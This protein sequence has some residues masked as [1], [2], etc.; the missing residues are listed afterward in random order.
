MTHALM[1]QYK[2]LYVIDR[3]LDRLNKGIELLT[4][5][6][7]LNSEKEKQKFFASKY[8][9]VP[10]FRYPK[11]NF[12]AFKLQQGLFSNNLEE[13]HDEQIRELYQKIGRASCRER[14]E[15]SEVDIG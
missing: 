8:T 12:N 1:D 15:I 9:E 10:K 2:G 5:L 7:P 6:N 14:V 11:R 4:Y 13:I 3:S